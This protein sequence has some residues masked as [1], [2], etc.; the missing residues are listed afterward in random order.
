[1][2]VPCVR[3]ASDLNA[4]LPDFC[5][6]FPPIEDRRKHFALEERK[7]TIPHLG[8]RQGCY[9]KVVIDHELVTHF[10][11]TGLD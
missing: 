11:K 7:P 3:G 4:V 8:A 9:K 5:R 2:I 1:M 6:N 10:C